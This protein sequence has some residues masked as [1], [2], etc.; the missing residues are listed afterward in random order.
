MKFNLKNIAF[1]LFG[2]L[3]LASCG[4]DYDVEDYFD[5]EELPGYVA[6]DVNESNEAVLDTMFVDETSG[7]ASFSIECPT[8]TLSD[9]NITYD[10]SGNATAGVDYNITNAGSI[11][12]ET[13]DTD[14][15]NFDRVSLDIEI[16]TDDVADGTKMITLTL[17]GASNAEGSLAV[18]RGGT[19][20]LKTAVLVI[21]DVD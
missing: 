14:F 13:K 21:A 3:V 1:F 2:A 9:I 20:Y 15:Q 11:T 17:T 16:L 12:L 18:G 6:F 8:G 4:N 19:D 5:L 7:M 10:V